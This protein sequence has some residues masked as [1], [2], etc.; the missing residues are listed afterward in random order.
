MKV[1][2]DHQIFTLQEYGGIS[3][4]FYELLKRFEVSDST[5]NVATLYSNNEYLKSVTNVQSNSFLGNVRFRGKGRLLQF[6]NSQYSSYKIRQSDFDVLHPTYYDPY[7]LKN[8]GSK[9]FV[10]TL[11]DM[12][13]EKFSSRFKEIADPKL[14]ERKKQLLENASKIIAVSESTKRDIIDYFGVSKSSIEVV[15]LGN[16][17]ISSS[18]NEVPIIK[19]SYILY[20]G[21]RSAYKNFLFFLKTVSDLL[22]S[23]DLKLVCAG[24]GPFTD[25]EKKAIKNLNLSAI[26]M[27]VHFN[28]D[29]VLSNLYS[30]AI[31]FVF[32][33]LYEGFGIPVLESFACRCPIITTTGGSLPEV[34]G[35]AAVYFSPD[36]P[37]S[38]H[39]AVSS[40]INDCELR[41]E[42]RNRGE[43]RLK[44][45][46][47]D[48]TFSKTLKIYS[49]L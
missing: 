48:I 16:S 32:P 27:Y 33:S 12:I 47:W 9:P 30:N 23:N 35:D 8:I 34:A 25:E 21:I 22:V 13:H 41:D 43:E 39:K 15:Y 11:H 5:F 6:I 31:C 44:L 46:S 49:S 2:Y 10:I 17:L 26:V 20:V 36:D 37:E 42:M 28:E 45:F 14:F 18:P 19:D 7:V 3:R 24:G 4:Y 29:R 38:L 1:T 40:V